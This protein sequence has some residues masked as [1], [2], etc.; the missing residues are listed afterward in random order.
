MNAPSAPSRA[1]S[2]EWVGLAVLFLPC[3]VY[4]MDL[5]VLNLAVPQLTRD[6]APSAD[7]LLWILDIYGFFVAGALVTMGTLG[8][9]IGR[10]R[11]LMMGALAFAAASLLAAFATTAGQ[12]IVARG[13]LGLAGATLAPSTLSL[14]RNMFH[15]EVQRRTAIAVW[16]ASFSAGTALGPVIGG[17]LLEHYWWGS[18]FLIN[19]PV[20][21]LLLVLG[22]WLLPEFRDPHP[23]RLDL[24]SAGLSLAAVLAMI[25]GVK[26]IATHGWSL[27]AVAIACAGLLLAVVFLRRQRRLAHPFVDLTLFRRA[28]FRMALLMNASGAFLIGGAWLFVAQFLQL[29]LGLSP[30][31]AALWSLPPALAFILGSGVVPVLSHRMTVIGLMRG[32]LLLSALGFVVLLLAPT[33]GLPVQ[34]VIGLTIFSFGFTPVASLTTDLIVTAVPP[35]KAG[36]AAALSETAF[37]LGGALGIAML[38]ALGAMLY[39]LW[40]A[41]AGGAADARC[42]IGR[43]RP[44]DVGRSRRSSGALSGSGRPIARGRPRRV[45]GWNASQRAAGSGVPAASGGVRNAFAAG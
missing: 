9:R 42:R 16:M 19:V 7:E 22:V 29:V 30:F 31:H 36:S 12:L 8:D 37:E 20:M 32:G 27:R 35:E 14:I 34:I 10:R 4:A 5:T 39:R 13:I 23:E 25:Y 3:L 17:L 44:L 15:D 41:E 18:V 11:L 33:T 26:D 28:A 24:A 1:G 43:C 2:R 40:M 21:A 6:L 38:G 45:H